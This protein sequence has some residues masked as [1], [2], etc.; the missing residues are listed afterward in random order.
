MRERLVELIQES[1]NGCARNWA[2]VIADHLIA[3]DVVVKD[4]L[5]Q[6]KCHVDIP[7][8]F[9]T[10]EECE[11]I[12]KKEITHWLA[13]EFMKHDELYELRMREDH[14]L[15]KLGYEFKTVVCANKKGGAE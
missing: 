3:N 8:I 11:S 7:S 1:V 12:A 5:V 2:E 13:R 14:I 15:K 6:L 4:N 10:K 9:I